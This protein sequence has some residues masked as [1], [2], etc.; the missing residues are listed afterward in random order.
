[1][2]GQKKS[3]GG[4]RGLRVKRDVQVGAATPTSQS[5]TRRAE[6]WQDEEEAVLSAMKRQGATDLEVAR[7]LGRS[8]S[9]VNRH[10]AALGMRMVPKGLPLP[11]VRS[12]PVPVLAQGVVYRLRDRRCKARRGARQNPVG[13][14]SREKVE[15][16]A[17]LLGIQ[18]CAAGTLYLFRDVDSGCR[19]AYTN[20]DFV[21]LEV[22]VGA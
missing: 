5:S 18:R 17:E 13:L 15:R 14:F 20:R 11:E 9:A 1:M 21:D 16:R 6:P 19:L 7:A 10:V 12:I 2:N 8:R 22:G 3:P 4:N